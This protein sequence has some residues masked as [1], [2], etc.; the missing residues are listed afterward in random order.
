MGSVLKRLTKVVNP[1]ARRIA[2][3]GFIP[4]WGVIVH[5]GRKSGR[6]FATPI[7]LA[8]TRDGFV[9][10]LPWGEGTDWCR[11]LL[12]AHGG[13][14]RWGGR[15]IPVREPE[16]IDR[17]AAAPEFGLIPRRM[18]GLIGIERFVRVRTVG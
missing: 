5:T 12:A 2:E 6:K 1:P 13:V 17:A 15:D 9:I 4:I 14:V 3:L 8:K 7:A 10:P 11:N 18:V 16:I